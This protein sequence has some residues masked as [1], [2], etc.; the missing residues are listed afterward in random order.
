MKYTNE[1]IN[2]FLQ[3]L[4]EEIKLRKYSPQTLKSY[5]FIVEKYLGSGKE[6]REFLLEYADKSRS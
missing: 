6:P 2:G 5:K 1:E 3:K 4:S